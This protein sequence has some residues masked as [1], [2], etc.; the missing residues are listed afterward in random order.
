MKER[1]QELFESIRLHL[2]SKSYDFHKYN[3]KLRKIN[4]IHPSTDF[5]LNKIKDESHMIYFFVAN[6]IQYYLENGRYCSFLPE[7]ANDNGISIY[8][9]FIKSL[10]NVESNLY[11]DIETLR[12]KNE[13]KKMCNID[14]VI[15]MFYS[16]KISLF[17]ILH[18]Y[19]F[20]KLSE[21]WKTSK[22]PLSIDF[23][24]FLGKIESF[25]K[26]K[27]EIFSK[28]LKKLNNQ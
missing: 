9:R 8:E 4:K 12:A 25:L 2:N 13:F 28:T 14:D 15:V 7:I 19:K 11:V 20:S 23:L 26:F 10:K 24:N 6:Q 27:K 18:F 1:V 16:K 3:G 17:T 5:L 22:N 21:I